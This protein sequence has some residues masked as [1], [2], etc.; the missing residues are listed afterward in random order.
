MLIYQIRIPKQQDAEAFVTF[1][2]EEY[3]PAVHEGPT[4]IG[5][6]TDLVLLQGET[7]DT[8]HEFFWHIGWSGLSSG[9]PHVGD[10][11]VLHKF[12]SF[13]A[14]VNRIGFYTEVAAW[15]EDN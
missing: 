12:D 6:A 2:R 10:E 5:Q 11:E 15:P 7:T 3:F 14:S 8:M 13:G 1:M 9:S 4:R